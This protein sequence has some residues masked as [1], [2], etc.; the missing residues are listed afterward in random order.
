V[1]ITHLGHSCLLVETSGVRILIDP[2]T[3][4]H[5]FEELTGLDAVLITHQH[6]DHLDS[7]RLPALLEAN[8]GTRLITEPEVA[9]ELDKVGL[10]AEPLHAGE[11]LDLAGV[12]LGGV[13]GVHAEIH[14]DIPRV[15]NIGIVMSA[16]GEPALFHPGD[17]Y[18]VVPEDVDVLALPLSAPWAKVS[19][20][21]EFA[22]AVA[23]QVAF[24]IHDEV[25]SGAGRGIYMG[26]VTRLL[27]DGTTLVDLRGR[28]ATTL[29]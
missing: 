16:P 21:I 6:A 27:P 8:D 15:G 1:N 10:S 5:G 24:P 25:A 9:V 13:G 3:F 14:P 2:G 11:S 26:A 18:D 17:C 4:S 19:E 7:D 22:R 29:P 23:P 28:G 12:S 20:T